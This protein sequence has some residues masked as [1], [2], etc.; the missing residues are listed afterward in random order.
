[1]AL[2]PTP[3]PRVTTERLVLRELRLQDFEAYAAFMADPV[4]TRFLT[5]TA[6]RRVAWRGFAAL[7]GQW[8]LN[9]AGWWGVEVAAT[10][11][12]VGTVGAFFRETEIGKGSDA[13]L[14]V[15]WT[16][17]PAHQRRGYATEAARAAL[18]HGFAHHDVKRA[19]AYVGT[20]NVASS[21]VALAIGMTH[22]GETEF[23]D[24]PVIRY[25]RSRTP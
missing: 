16:V 24:E 7:S 23:W 9:G 13:V 17:Y 4:A 12:M 2:P 11:E 10:G 18:A 6:D 5:Q 15:G 1:M 21:K 14:E 20:E 19:I 3:V 22:D 8:L 25:A